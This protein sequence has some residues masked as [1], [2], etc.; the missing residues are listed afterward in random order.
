MRDIEVME[1][2]LLR[3]ARQPESVERTAQML[4]LQ[5]RIQEREYRASGRSADVALARGESATPPAVYAGDEPPPWGSELLAFIRAAFFRV[6]EARA[7]RREMLCHAMA[8]GFAHPA[9]PSCRQAALA[10]GC[11]HEE[12]SFR[13]KE[14]QREYNLP[15]NQFNK[16]LRACEKYKQT[17]GARRKTA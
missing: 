3:L 8:F 2:E 6:L 16:S 14:I 5:E 17:N 1:T 7:P 9:Y 12:I 15:A 13:V 10:F 11:S 4:R